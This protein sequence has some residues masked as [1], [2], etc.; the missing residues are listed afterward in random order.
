MSEEKRK[1][2]AWIGWAA[3][4]LLVLLVLYP[5]SAGPAIW[6]SGRGYL[7]TSDAGGIYIPF[8]W[9]Y[10]H[11]PQRVRTATDSYLRLWSNLPDKTP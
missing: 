3:L 8:Q 2:R 7:L 4:A 1:T 9:A 10:R 11:A 5:L 6:F